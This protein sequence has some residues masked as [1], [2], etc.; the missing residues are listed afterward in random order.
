MQSSYNFARLL[1][2]GLGAPVGIDALEGSSQ[3]VVLPEPQ[4]VHGRQ[5]CDLAGAAVP[6]HKTLQPLTPTWVLS[7]GGWDLVCKRQVFPMVIKIL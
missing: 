4:R 3:A 2:D 5:G 6:S 1:V 7:T